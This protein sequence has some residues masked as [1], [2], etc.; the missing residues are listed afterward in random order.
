[1]LIE[2]FMF[3]VNDNATIPMSIE[4]LEQW[5]KPKNDDISISSVKPQCC[6]N[7]I[8]EMDE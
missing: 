1:M 5:I 8:K 6:D 7:I 2:G 4:E 3:E